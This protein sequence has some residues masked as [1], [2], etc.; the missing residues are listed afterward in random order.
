M[1]LPRWRLR[2]AVPPERLIRAAAP[3]L[4]VR[5][6]E[7]LTA[8]VFFNEFFTIKPVRGFLLVQAAFVVYLLLNLLVA[9]RYRLGHVSG[10]LLGFDIVAN[11]L[12]LSLPIAASG[13]LSSPLL[14]LLP[15]QAILYV[16]VFGE[17]AG[18][19]ALLSA[20]AMVAAIEIAPTGRSSSRWFRSATWCLAASITWSCLRGRGADR[21]AVG[22][23]L[24]QVGDTR[25]GAAPAR[26]HARTRC[27]ADRG[28]QRV[29]HRQRGGEPAHPLGRDPGDRRAGRPAAVS[30]WTYCGVALWDATEWHL[31][32]RRG[33]VESSRRQR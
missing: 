15:L 19:V 10:A 31:R 13:G 18:L 21:C 25:N 1:V 26:P 22:H 27:H 24:D 28:R 9:L 8:W 32:A 7:G 5:V 11:V 6:L 30:T 23:R 20:G 2:A 12:T 4:I 29:A 14:L 33:G 3:L 17:A 16:L